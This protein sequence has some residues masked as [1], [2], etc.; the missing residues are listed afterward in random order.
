M[1]PYWKRSKQTRFESGKERN[2]GIDKRKAGIEY[3]KTGGTDDSKVL[4]Y[5]KIRNARIHKQN[6]LGLQMNYQTLPVAYV[7][8]PNLVYAVKLYSCNFKDHAEFEATLS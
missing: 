7:I 4:E 3:R 8:R 6:L 2:V 1:K 5:M